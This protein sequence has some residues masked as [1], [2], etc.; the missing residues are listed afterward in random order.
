MAA[1]NA[2]FYY[3]VVANTSGS[4]QVGVTT[5]ADGQASKTLQPAPGQSQDTYMTQWA[6]M[7]ACNNFGANNDMSVG[8]DSYG[9]NQTTSRALFLNSL[10]DIPT[11]STITKATLSLFRYNAVNL[12]ATVHAY[13]VTRAWGEGTGVSSPASCTG[14]GA[15]WYEANGGVNWT[16]QGGDFATGASD[17]SA[18]VS[19]AANQAAGWDSYDISAIAQQWVNGG[20]PNLGVLLKYDTEVVQ[21]GN[22][23]SYWANDY[24]GSTSLRPKLVIT[25]QD[26]SHAIAPTVTMSAPA[27]GATV[28][29]TVV[30]LTVAA[31]DDHYVAKVEFYVDGALVGS[32]TSGSPYSVTWNSTGVANGSH[33]LTAKAYDD[34]GNTQT[35]A[36]STVSVENVAAPVTSV[37]APTG[38]TVSGTTTV[39]ASAS[40]AG[41]LTQVEFYFDNTRFATVPAV[42][43][44][45]AY[46]S[47]IHISEPTRP[48]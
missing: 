23:V 4:N 30:T 1:P 15:T 31:S 14:N 13:R 17:T 18:A 28:A 37:T 45:T 44:Q 19:L 27:S 46:L 42:A 11:N 34:A 16:N 9:T 39:T 48:L 5:P 26:G 47:L 7:Q 12:P 10:N 21:A 32:S 8:T 36:P 40:A 20:A 2:T 41:T 35:S 43:G 29:G 6:G 33:S 25:Y 22:E 3:A 24:T 38:G